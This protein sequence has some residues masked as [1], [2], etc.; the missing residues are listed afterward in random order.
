MP[1]PIIKLNVTLT[2]HFPLLTDVKILIRFAAGLHSLLL[3]FLDN[4]KLIHTY[5]L[6][7]K[8]NLYY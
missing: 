5:V 2:I 4:T 7:T 1:L 6:I 8:A 3:F